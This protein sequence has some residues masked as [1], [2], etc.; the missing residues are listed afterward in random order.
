MMSISSNTTPGVLA[1]T[2]SAVDGPSEP[3]AHVHARRRSPN[4]RNRLAGLLVERP[5]L[6][7]IREEHAIAGDDDAA[8][9]EALVGGLPSL[10]SNVHSS[11]PVA[12][13]SAKTRSLGVV[14]YSTPSTTIGFACISDP[15][16]SSCVSYVHATCSSRDV[17]RRDL[18]ERRVVRVVVAAAVD[19]PVD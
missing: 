16:N 4:D 10:G 12:A 11:R 5:Q 7:A 15:G 6:V 14:A 9:T 2:V 17:R 18:I 13:S 19:W 3:F 1:L 8:M